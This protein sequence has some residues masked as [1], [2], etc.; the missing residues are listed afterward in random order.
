MTYKAQV[1]YV[2]TLGILLL[3][4]IIIKLIYYKIENI[5]KSL[6]FPYVYFIA[7]QYNQNHLC[8]MLIRKPLMK[9]FHEYL[10]NGNFA[11][12]LCLQQNVIYN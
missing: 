2:H 10:N 7:K 1:Y 6:F 9:I 8:Y 11:D 12:G 4:N 3:R 5:L